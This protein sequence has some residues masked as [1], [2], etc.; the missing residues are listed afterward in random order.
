MLEQRAETALLR[1]QRLAVLIISVSVLKK[2]D[3]QG[4]P[5][6]TYANNYYKKFVEIFSGIA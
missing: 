5:I 4:T 6:L 1:E 3:A 2:L